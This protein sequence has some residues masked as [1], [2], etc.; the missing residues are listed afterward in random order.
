MIYNTYVCVGGVGDGQIVECEHYTVQVAER[1]KFPTKN[2]FT[3][4]Y[5][6]QTIKID[7]YHLET[8]RTQ[9]ADITFWLLN[10]MSI[11]D[12]LLKLFKRYGNDN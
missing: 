6:K 3:K 12:G 5:S 7:V 1:P 10:G 9:G 11:Q 2:P 8:L 4:D